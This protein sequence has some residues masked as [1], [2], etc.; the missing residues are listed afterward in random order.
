M[1]VKQIVAFPLSFSPYAISQ[2]RTAY[3]YF[4][5]VQYI[6]IHQFMTALSLCASILSIK[7]NVQN[8]FAKACNIKGQRP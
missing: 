1:S 4:Y 7:S 3:L 5:S 6:F 2:N 8:A